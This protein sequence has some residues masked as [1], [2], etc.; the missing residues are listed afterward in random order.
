MPFPAQAARRR[1][2]LKVLLVGHACGAGLG[3]EPGLTWNWAWHLAADHEVRVIAHGQFRATVERFLATRPNP[4]LRF[5][6]VAAPARW[7]PWN[8]ERGE[9]G[10]RLHYLLWQ[11]SATA[12]AFRLHAR[13]AF[14]IV[15]YVSWN[16]VSAPP[17]LWQMPVPFVWGPVGG[18]QTTPAAFRHYFGRAAVRDS[19]RTLRVKLLPRLPAL[20]R[21]VRRAALLIATNPETGALLEAAGAREVR[22]LVDNGLPGHAL[23]PWPPARQ[24]GDAL[25]LLW[26]GRLEPRKALP[27]ALE[28]LEAVADPRVRLVVAGDGPL[29]ADWQALAARR[30]LA[31]RVDFLGAVPFERMTAL[32][33]EADAF[34][35][36]SLRDSSASVVLEA[37]AQGL[38]ILALGHQGV[39]FFLADD[40]GIKVPVTSPRETVEGLARGIR[41]LAASP[42]ERARMGVAAWTFARSESWELRAAKMSSWYDELLAR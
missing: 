13:E 35:F 36:T 27:L 28:A 40:A 15:H 16:T 22:L 39:G 41:R 5:T 9:R 19:L 6:W 12:E 30:G 3:S 8:P 2:R 29:R 25:R 34:L 17:L 1:R 33:R 18:G 24:P 26:A 37:M 31:G 21:A 11:R 20:R 14:D 23:P 32:F 7:D 10:I 38:P 42:T 4:N